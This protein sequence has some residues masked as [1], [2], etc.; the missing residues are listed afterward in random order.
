M[1]YCILMIF[2][3]M[4]RHSFAQ[5]N[6]KI[7]ND[8]NFTMCKGNSIQ[9][10]GNAQCTNFQWLPAKNINNVNAI[11]PIVSPDTTTTYFVTAVDAN[12]C[13]NKDSITVN[14]INCDAPGRY[15][16]LSTIDFGKGKT[17][18]GLQVYDSTIPVKF[19]PLSGN[20]PSA[21]T[22]DGYSVVNQ[23]PQS[24]NNEW[25][26]GALNHTPN[27][28]DSGY[29]AV[30]KNTSGI[31][32]DSV[33]T[34]VDNGYNTRTPS[35]CR[36]SFS[37]AYPLS[38]SLNVACAGND[39]PNIP[40]LQVKI[41]EGS[42]GTGKFVRLSYNPCV[43]CPTGWDANDSLLFYPD[44]LITNNSN[45]MQWLSFSTPYTWNYATST[46]GGSNGQDWRIQIINQTPSSP[47]G[48]DIVLDDIH[49][50]QLI[51][52]Q[53]FSFRL[54]YDTIKLCSKTSQTYAALD[55]VN[56]SKVEFAWFKSLDKG[57]T[58][59]SINNTNTDRKT[60][61]YASQ[62][63]EEWIR[64]E[65]S[66]SAVSFLP[67]QRFQ[68]NYFIILSD[69]VFNAKAGNDTA[70]CKGASLQ[71]NATGGTY[72]LWSPPDYLSNTNTLN[73]LLTPAISMQYILQT[74]NDP[75]FTASCTTYDTINIQVDEKPI[76][77]AGNNQTIHQGDSTKMNGVVTGNDVLLHWE[78]KQF[79]TDNTKLNAICKPDTTRTFYLYADSKY[80]CGTGLDSMKIIVTTAAVVIPPTTNPSGSNAQII[81]N[82]FSPNGDGINDTWEIPLLKSYP[83]CS[84]E[85][86][87]RYGQLVFRSIGY[88]KNWDGTLNNQPLPIGTYYYIIKTNP[89]ARLLSGSVLIIR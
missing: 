7:I 64:L 52:Y 70:I 1:R 82:A 44:I 15:V 4:A 6:N 54:P 43:N 33:Y 66:M 78:P 21:F 55:L 35:S 40:S 24:L 69:A 58:W 81:P 76:V 57:K 75:N 23:I 59:Q 77:V 28:G 51:S 62:Q 50:D 83:N 36:F 65:G 85:V 8:Y 20:P 34:F 25:R 88:N 45:S 11:S 89:S 47:C 14:V 31:L 27:Q 29:M 42:M 13:L 56:T 10:N 84:V 3:L 72:N 74:S 63:K 68:S 17:N 16:N 60:L 67:P 18:P 41:I 26:T 86:Y 80:G 5:C 79:F 30:F 87:S 49:F 22:T 71:L 39:L 46:S 2:V 19:I 53:S 48:N 73:P 37:Y 32:F 9:I 12:G 38:N 61:T